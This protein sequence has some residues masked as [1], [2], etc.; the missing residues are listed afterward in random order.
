MKTILI[1]GA[2]GFVG[3][4]LAERCINEGNVVIGVDDLSSGKKENLSSIWKNKSFHFFRGDM[5]HWNA[6]EQVMSFVKKK[7]LRPSC[8]VELIARKIPRYGGRRDTLLVNSKSM[9]TACELARQFRSKLIFASTSDVYGLSKELPFR[10]DGSITLGPSTVGRWSYAASKYFGEQLAF[11]YQEK[12]HIPIV[13][14]RIFGVYG[15][16]QVKGWKGNAVSAFFEQ[17]FQKKIY[18]LHHDGRQS[19]SFLYISD[20]IEGLM[21]MIVKNT[22]NN[23][24]VNLGSTEQVSMRRLAAHIHKLI[25]PRIKFQ[26][27]YVPYLSFT[28]RPYQDVFAK[29]PDNSKAERLLGWVPKV[30]LREGLIKTKEWYQH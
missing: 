11:A 24:I 15:P 30:S 21:A 23:E 12:F 19:R 27:K 5:T 20:L 25:H 9:M 26:F 7:F 17:A 28:G 18:E 6:P 1:A 10:E 16:R 8:V 22:I 2:A 29:L 4:H 13:I 3:S 14:A